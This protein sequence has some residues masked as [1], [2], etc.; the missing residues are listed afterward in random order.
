M[1]QKRG[2]KVLVFLVPYSETKYDMM[3]KIKHETEKAYNVNTN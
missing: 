2:R 3:E 1:H